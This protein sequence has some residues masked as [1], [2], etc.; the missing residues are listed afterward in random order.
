[1]KLKLKGKILAL[2]LIPLIM[3]GTSM[4]IVAANRIANGIYNEAYL[5]MQATTLAVKDIFEIGYEGPYT[6]NSDGELWKGTELNIS[7]AYDIVDHIKENTGLEVTVFWNDTR[8]LTSITDANGN[9]QIGTTASSDIVQRVLKDGEPYHNRNVDILGTKYV[10]YYT[11]FYQE[12]SS[13][14][15]GMVFLGTPQYKIS[16]II[17]K[18]RFQ[19]LILIF[20]GMIIAT[21]VVYIIV[22]KITILLK[23]SMGYLNDISH[24][25]LDIQIEDKILKRSD[26]IGALGESI[27]SLRDELKSIISGIRS[28][29]DDVYNES[30][31]LEQI[32]EEVC[33][34]MEEISQS[35]QEIANSSSQQSKDATQVG[36]NVMSMGELIEENGNEITRLSDISNTMNTTAKQAMQ[37]LGEMNSVMANV[38]ESMHFL[39]EQTGLT[40]GSVAKI[41]SA[42]ELITNIASQTNLLSLNAS[43][44]AARA[45]EHGQGFAVV[46]AEIQQ[47]SEQSNTAAKEIKRIVTTLNTHS[48]QTLEHVEETQNILKKQTESFEETQN[49]FQCAQDS[50][51]ETVSGMDMIKQKFEVLENV[52]TDTIAIVQNASALSEEN[53]ASVE[54][55][56]AEIETVY[57][58]IAN[59]S[60][61]TKELNGLSQDMKN[62]IAIFNI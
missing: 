48:S 32:T 62:K 20:A 52:R 51:L 35:M 33:N 19:L 44:E 22:N 26:E 38:C 27:S 2:S 43:I 41:S 60:K 50:V 61:K 42:T 4:F 24:G 49:S 15:V 31:S 53:S 14:P 13:E 54:E 36:S 3:L 57:T 10:V 45:G 12:N 11:P 17:N 39:E 23:K 59:I 18:T 28:Q 1:M 56:M 34:I 58:N 30:D 29:S 55:I 6:M 21:I 8:I 40:N 16:N 47:L 46:A 37:Q 9:R 5:G 7:Q 25:N